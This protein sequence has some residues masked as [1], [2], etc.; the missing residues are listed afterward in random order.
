MNDQRYQEIWTHTPDG[1]AMCALINDDRGWLMYLRTTDDA[2][3][4]SPC[5]GFA[6]PDNAAIEYVLANGQRDKY[7]A[8]WA[9]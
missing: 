5:P 8:L 6:G 1:Q 7:P 2:G 3:F 9:I 4:S